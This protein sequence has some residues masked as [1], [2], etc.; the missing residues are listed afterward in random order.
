MKKTIAMVDSDTLFKVSY[1]LYLI[2][3][4]NAGKGNGYISNTVFQVSSDPVKFATC[5]S[6]NNYTSGL[7]MET[8]A[9]SVSVLSTDVKPQLIATF[10]YRSGRDIDKL[11]AFNVRYG[12]TGVPLITESAVAV[13]EF[14]ILE[15]VDVGTHFLFIAGLL[16]SEMIDA[17]KEPMTYRYY[18][19]VRKGFAPKNA[20]TY[21]DKSSAGA[22]S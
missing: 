16:N 10:G 15:T 8:G 19:E 6:K 20:P 4:G 12:Q 11:A 7:I 3:S 2:C 17:T 1:G 13:F 14:R 9:F 22:K 5:C 18:R 21:I